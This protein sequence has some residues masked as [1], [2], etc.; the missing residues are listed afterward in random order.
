[1]IT[2]FLRRSHLL[3]W[4][5]TQGCGESRNPMGPRWLSCTLL[6]LFCLCA[7]HSDASPATPTPTPLAAQTATPITALPVDCAPLLQYQTIDPHGA[8]CIAIIC[9][10]GQVTRAGIDRSAGA[11]AP[12]RLTEEQLTE[13]RDRI[14]ESDFFALESYYRA[15]ADCWERW[16]WRVTVWRDGQSKRVEAENQS[17]APAGLLRLFVWVDVALAGE[18]E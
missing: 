3:W 8:S 5:P 2:A 6:L 9:E 18:A 17:N 14:A 4:R 1:M 10:D 7:C 13:L 16:T 15:S 11:K 12:E